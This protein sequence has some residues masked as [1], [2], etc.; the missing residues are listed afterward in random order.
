MCPLPPAGA[1]ECPAQQKY[2]TPH[3]RTVVP[4]GLKSAGQYRPDYG[5]AV[6]VEKGKPSDDYIKE[7]DQQLL[8]SAGLTDTHKVIAE[9]WS[10]GPRSELPPGHWNVFAQWVSRRDRHSLD[11]DA[12]LFFALNNALLDASITAWDAK[13][14]W[15]SV[16]PIT[17]VRWLKRGQ[18]VRAWGG[19]YQGTKTIRGEDW[20][21][22]QPATFPTPPF[23]EYISGPLHL[24]RRR[25]RGAPGV[26]RQRRPGHDDYLPGRQLQGRARC[27]A[28]GAGDLVLEVVYRRRRPGR[29]VPPVRRD[30]L[31]G[32]RPGGKGRRERWASRP[33]TRPS[34]TSAERPSSSPKL[35]PR[36]RGVERRVVLLQLMVRHDPA[37]LHSGKV[38]H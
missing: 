3:W 29:A 30:P 1:T 16:R 36:R 19:P 27:G 9:Y 32:R 2:L 13:R 12:K 11:R 18:L 25:R 38:G 26:H 14:Q 31:Q 28:G 23:P 5:P 20:L 6:S 22:D 35:G 33:W 10:D 17:A 4:F 34:P 21:P 24:Q 37:C 8:Y 15:D 7:V